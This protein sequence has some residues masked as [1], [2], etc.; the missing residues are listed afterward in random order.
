M[1]KFAYRFFGLFA[2][3]LLLGSLSL[4]FVSCDDE[5]D[6]EDERIKVT[7][8]S[9]LATYVYEVD[10]TDN[11][12]TFIFYDEGSAGNNAWRQDFYDDDEKKHTTLMF[13]TWKDTEAKEADTTTGTDAVEAVNISSYFEDLNPAGL[14][15]QEASLSVSYKSEEGEIYS[16]DAETIK[17]GFAAGILTYGG[18]TYKKK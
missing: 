10:G 9:V 2:A 15:E 13:G 12:Y 14:T 5:D 3:A 18:N 7:D 4:A 8:G 6:E 17:V 11:E 1:K 16:E